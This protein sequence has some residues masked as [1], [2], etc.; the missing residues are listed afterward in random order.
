MT[1]HF[2]FV[3]SDAEAETIM[4]CIRSEINQSKFSASFPDETDGY[5]EWHTNRVRYLEELIAKMN[6]YSVT[7]EV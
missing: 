7:D 2:D 6:N 4:D 1:I 5:R 3:V